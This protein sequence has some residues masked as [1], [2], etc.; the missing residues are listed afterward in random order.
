MDVL[1]RPYH[2]RLID[3]VVR[4]ALA[5][6][7]AVLIEGARAC[8]KTTT[9]LHAAASHVF[10]DDDAAQRMRV[11]APQTLLDG[12]SPRLVD[13]W[14]SAPEL[15][16]MIRRRVDASA[17]PGRFILTGS[18][19]PADDVTRHT[20][21][22]RLLRLRQRTMTWCEKDDAVASWPTTV[23]LTRLFAGDRP[24]GDQTAMSLDDVLR[25]VVKSGFPGMIGLTVPTAGRLMRGYLDEVA[26]TDLPRLIDMRRDPS[27]IARLL[28]VIARNVASEVSCSTLAADVRAVAPN[29]TADTVRGYVDALERLFVVER[30]PAWTPG[31]RSRARLRTSHTWH[32]A[33]P[34][35]AATALAASPKSLKAD[36]NTAALLFESAVVHD[37]RV[38]GGAVGADVRRFRDSNG[39]EI[40]AVLALPDGRWAGVEIKLSGL[41][42]PAGA[43]SLAKAIE[44]IDQTLVGEPAFRLVVTGM[45]STFTLKDGTV[46]CPLAALRP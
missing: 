31:L 36:P 13:E 14:Q 24:A 41:Q 23:S 46:T 2:P 40:D 18:A 37:L 16:N 3:P 33:D 42:V 10:V 38:L 30:Q 8:G 12:A 19:A 25:L 5:S 4:G 6:A 20:G 21:A 15:W 35:L 43:E 27:V 7:G 34:A 44:Q 29:I 45:G 9:G 22:G 11:I 17:E 32:L 1:R 26:R 39:H 28:A